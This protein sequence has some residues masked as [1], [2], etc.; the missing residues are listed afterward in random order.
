M[1]VTIR[2]RMWNAEDGE[3]M[4]ECDAEDPLV[5]LHGADNIAPGLERGLAGKTAGAHVELTLAPEQAFGIPDP[6]AVQVLAREEFP[7]EAELEP[8]TVFGAFDEN[9]QEIVVYVLDAN[10]SEIT[11]TANHPLAGLTLRY[12]IDVV[13][14][15]EA[16][17]DELVHGHPHDAH[18][19]GDED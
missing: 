14:V 19:C 12:E 7:P 18:G 10:A 4:D 8:G 16:S 11:V 1:V 2:Y 9:E 17:P 3:L 5:Y 13:D 15:R 6:D